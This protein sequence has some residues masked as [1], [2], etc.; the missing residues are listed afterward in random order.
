MKS[1]IEIREN[2]AKKLEEAKER[3]YK[4]II[5]LHELLFHCTYIIARTNARLNEDSKESE[6]LIR[7]L[8]EEAK[9][10]EPVVLFENEISKLIQELCSDEKSSILLFGD[11]DIRTINYRTVYGLARKIAT[12]DVPD[13]LKDCEI[14]A[15]NDFESL[16]ND[17]KKAHDVIDVASKSKKTILA[18]DPDPTSAVP[19]FYMENS[20]KDKYILALKTLLESGLRCIIIKNER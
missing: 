5:T 3:Y 18:F 9:K 2:E 11:G 13:S 16:V 1:E 12:G 19:T 7:N 10:E 14:F 6:S 15:L 8:T 4:G 20:Q 17:E